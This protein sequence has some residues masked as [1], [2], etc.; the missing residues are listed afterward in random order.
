MGRKPALAA[1]QAEEAREMYRGPW[2]VRQ[3]ARYFGVSA[4]VVRAALDRT[5]AYARRDTT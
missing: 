5:G 1:E 3:I 4:A 2:T